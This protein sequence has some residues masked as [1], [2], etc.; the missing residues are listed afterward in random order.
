MDETPVDFHCAGTPGQLFIIRK[1]PSVVDS[2]VRMT[3]ENLVIPRVEKL[4]KE[5][6]WSVGVTAF[7]RKCY[8]TGGTLVSVTLGIFP[9]AF[10]VLQDKGLGKNAIME[11]GSYVGGLIGEGIGG[12]VAGVLSGIVVPLVVEVAEMIS[13]G[14]TEVIAGAIVGVG[15]GGVGAIIGACFGGLIAVGIRFFVS[16]VK[17]L[18]QAPPGFRDKALCGATLPRKRDLEENFLKSQFYHHD[19][20]WE[21]TRRELYLKHEHHLVGH[22]H[23]FVR[24]GHEF[25]GHRHEFVGHGHQF[26]KRQQDPCFVKAKIDLK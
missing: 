25:V 22:G 15:F 10:A 5:L 21:S 20:Q 14:I 9:I 12:L 19:I 18:L 3:K 26:L 11:I 24:H 17:G 7:V 8:Q 1:V 16:Y 6:K 4:L 23:E 2:I 13:L